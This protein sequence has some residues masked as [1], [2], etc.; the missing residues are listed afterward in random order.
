MKK[1]ARWLGTA[2]VILLLAAYGFR[3]DTVTLP[4]LDPESAT[5]RLNI[6]T[7]AASFKWP[8]AGAAA[9]GLVG[10][11]L[12]LSHGSQSPAPIASTAKLITALSVL[13][14]K[15][16]N[17]EQ[18]GPAITLGANDVALYDNYKA[19]GGS[20]V[21]VTDGEQISEYQMLEAMLLPSANNM[22]DSLATW[23]FG[24][25]GAYTSFANSY[26]GQLG[27]TDTHVGSDASGFDPSTTSTPSDLVKLGELVMQNPVLAGTVDQPSASDIP[28]TSLVHNLNNLL[29]TNNIVGIKTGNTA[30]AGG[31]FISA[32][33]VAVNGHQQTIVTALMGAPTLSDA[34]N[35]SLP[36][37][38]SAQTNFQPITIVPS[39][40]VVGHYQL[41]WGGVTAVVTSQNLS[42]DAWKGNT[43]PITISLKKISANSPAGQ[44]VGEL[45][46]PA[47]AFNDA[48]SVLIKL[49]TTPSKPTLWWR[50]TH[51]F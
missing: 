9:V 33:Q 4:R 13:H 28:N 15:P 39:G 40:A 5:S 3:V 45:S 14:G 26:V 23:A 32:S 42:L 18:Q 2:V 21:P 37:I 20:V 38:Q 27:L 30:Q 44:P 43:I 12:L 46:T 1:V 11:K 41:P 25:L 16:L 22:A 35:E 7:P 10:S 34:L 29:G 6:Q 49:Q 24:S 47:S 8:A 19:E 17:L 51:P 50:L 31:V 36:L 48:Q